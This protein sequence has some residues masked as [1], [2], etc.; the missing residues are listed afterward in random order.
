MS[1]QKA[2]HGFTLSS[3][4]GAVGGDIESQ[5]LFFPYVLHIVTPS[6]PDSHCDSLWK[7]TYETSF[8]HSDGHEVDPV[9]YSWR[10]VVWG[11]EKGVCERSRKETS[12]LAT[13][14]CRSFVKETSTGF[15]HDH[16][17][18]W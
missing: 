10:K 14:S 1:A 5:K 13:L 18:R 9:V 7:G 4:N 16:E 15:W 8:H 17:A 6:G 11:L 3:P 12:S 2:K